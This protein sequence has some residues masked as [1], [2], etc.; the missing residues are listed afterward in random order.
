[1]SDGSYS[2]QPPTAAS[3]ADEESG[4]KE[5]SN[6]RTRVR[7]QSNNSV[8]NGGRGSYKG[9][10]G[11]GTSLT[12][13]TTAT[14]GGGGR[15]GRG[16]REGGRGGGR[17]EGRG[18]RGDRDRERR[19]SSANPNNAANNLSEQVQSLQIDQVYTTNIAAMIV[20]KEKGR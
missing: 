19:P 10:A 8:S 4:Y 11:A 20:K 14:T 7:G 15:G 12:P 1:M 6:S 2:V 17:G 13:D 3:A 18:G 5:V 9:A 16:N